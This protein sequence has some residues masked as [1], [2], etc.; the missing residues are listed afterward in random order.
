MEE[1]EE[2]E[3]IEE[4]DKEKLFSSSIQQF[5][6]AVTCEMPATYYTT[7]RK[8][9]CNKCAD[10]GIAESKQPFNKSYCTPVE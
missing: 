10:C 1:K 9:Y 4:A 8:F 2:I 3:E 5:I 7:I 6:F